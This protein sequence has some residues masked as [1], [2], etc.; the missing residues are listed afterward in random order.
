MKM[1]RTKLT[2]FI[3]FGKH[4]LERCHGHAEYQPGDYS[5]KNGAPQRVISK[6]LV[7]AQRF[8]GDGEGSELGRADEGS[9]KRCCG[10][11]EKSFNL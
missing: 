2:L 8:L 3:H 9:G 10:S 1:K 7:I 4:S 5:S 11:S 6:Q